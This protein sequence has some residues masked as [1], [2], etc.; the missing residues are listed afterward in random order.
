KQE[1]LFAVWVELP[2]EAVV[3]KTM[4]ALEGRGVHVKFLGSKEDALKILKEFIPPGVDVMT[5]SSTTL[6]EIGFVE[7][8][9]LGNHPWN[10]LKD[11]IVSEKD[12]KKQAELRKKSILADYFLGSVHAVSQSGEVI[13][14]SNTGSQL[15][16]YAFS[17]SNVVWVVGT[18]KIVSSLE[19]GLR[20]VHEYCLPLEDQRMKQ[21]GFKGCSIGK[22]LIFE[23]ETL[24]FRKVTLFFVNE[25]LGF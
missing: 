17:S 1:R 2:D 9:K 22:I 16:P 21:A 19:E 7:L 25:K 6:N 24:P 12:P 4:E 18:Q 15:A 10:N 3:K 23:R 13:T 8:L 20:R 11:K 14:A 5:G